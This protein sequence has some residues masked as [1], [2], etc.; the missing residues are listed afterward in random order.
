MSKKEESA[1]NLNMLVEK[2]CFL[3][4]RRA[5]RAKEFSVKPFAK[6]LAGAR[7]GSPK[8]SFHFSAYKL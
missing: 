5:K 7:G 2:V 1:L 4:K 6:G 3:K 8:W